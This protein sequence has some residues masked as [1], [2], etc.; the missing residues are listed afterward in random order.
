MFRSTEK[1]KNNSNLVSKQEKERRGRVG[2]K[3]SFRNGETK[4]RENFKVI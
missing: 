1:N 2:I 4:E 3:N